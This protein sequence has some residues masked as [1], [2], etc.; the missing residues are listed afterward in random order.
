MSQIPLPV[1][2]E[3]EDD[4]YSAHITYDNFRA[5]YYRRLGRIASAAME[6]KVKRG[7]YAGCAPTGYRNTSSG[8]PEIDPVLGPLTLE[9]FHLASL[10]GWSLRKVL[11]VMTPK[12][13]VS[14]NGKPMGA[15]AFRTLL[16][17]PFYIGLIRYKDRCYEGKHKPLVPATMWQKV[18]KRLRQRRKR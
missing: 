1:P 13:F 10:Q 2:I 5:S 4:P 3:V 17:N 12:G 6:Q 18:Q 8:I 9:A 11:G 16:R 15:S 14:R 7:Q